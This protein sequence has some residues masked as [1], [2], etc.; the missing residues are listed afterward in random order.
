MLSFRIHINLWVRKV[1]GWVHTEVP[2]LVVH[3]AHAVS[4]RIL[5]YLDMWT[6][7]RKFPK[8]WVVLFT[9]ERNKLIRTE[10]W[11][12]GNTD[13][14]KEG[15]KTALNPRGGAEDRLQVTQRKP[16]CRL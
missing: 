10:T 5:N 9:Y 6:Y 11:K 16:K 12:D 14:R 1:R 8:S 15:I 3:S 13:I 4:P 2:V 7:S